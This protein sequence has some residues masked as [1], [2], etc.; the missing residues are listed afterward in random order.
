M[1]TVL[2]ALPLHFLPIWPSLCWLPR[3]HTQAQS[4]L[5]QNQPCAAHP[6][7]A[8]SATDCAAA[9]CCSYKYLESVLLVMLQQVSGCPPLL[10]WPGIGQAC[11]HNRHT[12][13]LIL[14]HKLL[15]SQVL[16][17]P[18]GT[19][20]AQHASVTLLG[21]SLYFGRA[22]TLRSCCCRLQLRAQPAVLPGNCCA[23]AC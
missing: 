11:Q 20:P 5:W 8:V 18:P 19:Q 2:L 6:V 13:Y 7:T 22:H 10:C 16:Q 12:R 23:P 3:K 4:P 9:Q 1:T 15:N 14:R 21:H 17:T